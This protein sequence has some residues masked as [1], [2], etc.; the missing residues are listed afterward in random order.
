MLDRLHRRDGWAALTTPEGHRAKLG[1]SGLMLVA[2]AE[3]RLATGDTRHD[4]VMRELGP[5]P[6]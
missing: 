3:R 6:R 2:L 4:E 1:S 5:V